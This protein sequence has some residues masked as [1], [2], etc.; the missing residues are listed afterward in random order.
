MKLGNRTPRI[1][2]AIGVGLAALILGAAACG[3]SDSSETAASSAAPAIA[4]GAVAP[5]SAAGAAQPGGDSASG[6]GGGAAAAPPAGAPT[7]AATVPALDSRR[8]IRTADLQLRLTV[9]ADVPDAELAA[10]RRE[11]LDAAVN[12][13]R[14]QAITEGGFVG[15][16]QQSN[17]S[18]SMVIR[19]PAGKFDDFLTAAAKLGEVTSR[20]ESAQDVTDEYTDV[21]SRIATMRTSVDRL[22]TLVAQATVV[23]DIIS[24]ESQ[25]TSREADLE[26][27]EGRLAVLK[28]QV[29]LSTVSVTFT[30]AR[31]SG[32]VVEP[33]PD[34]SGFLGG[35][36]SGWRALLDFLTAVGVFLGLILPFLPFAAILVAVIWIW[37]RRVRRGQP[38]E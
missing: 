12:N 31:D 14:A 7:G 9:G 35:L 26:S 18:A 30:V 37:R 1:T 6:A 27:L 5:G 17:G 21:E 15:D 36:A 8:V 29:G 10:A 25:L 34:R 20:T 16:L 2:A 32:A 22:R 13:A 33:A 3:S 11:A 19:I 23:A 24:I 28:D 4:G 38:V